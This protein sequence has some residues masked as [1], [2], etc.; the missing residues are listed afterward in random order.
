MEH[1]HT[2]WRFWG[3][4][5]VLSV[6]L[7]GTVDG[8][9][10]ARF[11][12]ITGPCHL[13]FPADHGVH[14]DFR[15]EWWYYTGNLT[16]SSG[17]RFGFQLTFFRRQLRPD[18]TS[19]N[20]PDPASAWRTN[21]IFLAH[22]ALTDLARKEHFM[23]EKV[24]RANLGMAGAVTSGR[25]TRVFLQ[26]WAAAITPEGHTL[27]MTDPA[28][29]LELRLVPTKGPVIHG[30]D[31]YSRK[32][33]RPEQASC[34]YSFPRLNV[35]GRVGVGANAYAVTGQGWMDHEFSTAPLA[36]G[37]VGW[38]W[39]SIQLD[40]GRE[41]MLYFLRR[42]DGGWQ[43]ASS[44]SLIDD[45]GRVAHLVLSDIETR[46]TRRWTSPAT[47]AHYPLGWEI[48]FPERNLKLNIDSCLDDQEMVTTGSTGVTY[49]EGCIAVKGSDGGT[50][51]TGKGYMELTGYADPYAPP[52]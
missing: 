26:Q 20:W 21:Q 31:G 11:R 22:A 18:A 38:D 33:D 46:V 30:E 49:W 28:F 5:L 4:L 23:A 13:Q 39:F 6:L 50:P 24:S 10:A 7:T 27:R 19:R 29:S 25:E 52:L 45:Q 35:S 43:A 47:G 8:E 48:I 34:Y 3:L 51:L 15:T 9:E 36:K 16:A 17:E 44:G 32:G 14:P 41:L 42:T 1:L 12:S 2:P 37:I 40:D